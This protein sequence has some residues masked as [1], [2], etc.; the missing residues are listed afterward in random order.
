M[1]SYIVFL[2]KILNP[3]EALEPRP[4]TNSDALTALAYLRIAALSEEYEPGYIGDEGARRLGV[5][6]PYETGHEHDRNRD[7]SEPGGQPYPDP[8]V[9]A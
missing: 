8:R 3:T 5:G 4:P 7:R 9:E 1:I 6:L 2:C